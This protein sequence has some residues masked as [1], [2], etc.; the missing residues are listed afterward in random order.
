VE[1]LDALLDRLG[2][3][4]VAAAEEIIVTY[5]PYLRR[6]VRRSLPAPLRSK[7]DSVDVVQSV[8]VHVLRALQARAWQFADRG[9]V[10][11]LLVTIARRR[12]IS[13]YRTHRTALAREARGAP[14]LEDVAARHQPRP[15]E[16]VQA[17]ELWQRMLALCPPDHH[18]VLRLRRQGVQLEEIAR[19]TGLHEGSVRRLLRR[20]ARQLAVQHEPFAAENGPARGEEP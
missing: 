5:E 8:W 20:L 9:R 6:I 2:Q 15:S 14:G 16:V 7:F 12:L 3:G 1:S 17:D 10:R 11:A 13:R 18:E 4:D 19:R